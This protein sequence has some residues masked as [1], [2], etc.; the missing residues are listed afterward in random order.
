MSLELLL[1]EVVS[2]GAGVLRV[3][4]LMQYC[5]LSWDHCTPDLTLDWSWSRVRLLCLRDLLDTS[6]QLVEQCFNIL[7]KQ[8]DFNDNDDSLFYLFSP[9][10]Q[11][12]VL[13]VVFTV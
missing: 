7:V 11:C 6:T 3:E 12:V 9:I 4:R 13:S 10:S 8:A 2:L 1:T 5:D